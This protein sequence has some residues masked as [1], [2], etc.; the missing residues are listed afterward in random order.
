MGWFSNPKC[1]VHGIE[2]EIGKD[3]MCQEYY[4]CPRC[5]KNK[6][7]QKSRESDLQNRLMVMEKRLNELESKTA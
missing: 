4:Y 2:M 3:Y 1:G 7:E 6:R 5:R